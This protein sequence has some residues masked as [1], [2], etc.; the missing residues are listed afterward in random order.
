MDEMADIRVDY[1]A[2]IA[3]KRQLIG[4]KQA[5]Q[6][7]VVELLGHINDLTFNG[8]FTTQVASKR[9]TQYSDEWEKGIQQAAKGMD[10][11]AKYLDTV[12]QKYQEVDNFTIYGG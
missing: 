7:K 3:G 6:Q 11:M 5:I 9:Y 4:R 2:L 1:D 10:E 12:M 8:G